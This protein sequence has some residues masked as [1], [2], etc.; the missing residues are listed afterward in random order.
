MNIVIKAS[1]EGS[2]AANL[3]G[4]GLSADLSDKRDEVNQDA[5]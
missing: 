2:N 3:T 1:V 4:I 5:Q